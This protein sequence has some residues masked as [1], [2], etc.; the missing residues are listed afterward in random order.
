M[1]L[2]IF[3]ILVFLVILNTPISIAIAI[4]SFIYLLIENVPLVIIPQQMFQIVNSFPFLA[5]P[6]F[7]LVGLL[8]NAGGTSSRIF[9]FAESLVGHLKGGLGH[10]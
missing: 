10:V 8:M 9:D 3:T 7:M 6:M 4:A 2:L 5:F 1:M